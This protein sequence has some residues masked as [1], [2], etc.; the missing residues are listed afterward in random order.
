MFKKNAI[1]LLAYPVI[2]AFLGV[3]TLL[4]AQKNVEPVAAATFNVARIETGDTFNLRVSITGTVAR[5]DSIDFSAW[6][7]VLPAH[8][9][10]RSTGWQQTENQRWE[11][12]WT[13]IA[14][15]SAYLN[16][17]GLP[18]R[19][20]NGKKATTNPLK[21]HVMSTTTTGEL[22]DMETVRDINYEPL[23]WYDYWPWAAGAVAVLG[24][25]IWA[26]RRLSRRTNALAPAVVQAV[27][28]PTAQE[29]AHD[30]ALRKLRDLDQRE[31]WQQRQVEGYYTALSRIVREYISRRFQL[32]ALESTT[33][34]IAIMLRQV[35]CQPEH[36]NAL[37]DLLGRADLA[38][39]AKANPTNDFHVKSMHAAQQ[40]VQMTKG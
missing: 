24:L 11:R 3:C 14:F 16:L 7:D 32:P 12:L 23:Q 6:Q 27:A 21:I 13:L 15:D 36:I 20:P 31:L 25:L 37:R 9:R 29:P 10:L 17:P 28:P 19:L 4:S 18:V 30:W 5:P 39:F 26:A 2:C 8:L 22:S 34:E 1:A 35:S 33:D 38:K 40:F